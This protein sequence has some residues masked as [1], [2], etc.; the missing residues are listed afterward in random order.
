MKK[1]LAVSGGVDSMCL[2]WKY[3]NDSNVVVA[4]FDHGTRASSAED[5]LFVEK[6][7]KKLNLPFCIE[8][9]KLGPKVSEEEARSYRYAFLKK[10][11]K[12]LDGEIYTAHHLNDLAESIAINLSRG[13]SWRGLT[14]FSDQTI[15][16]PFIKSG[17]TKNDLLK[18]AAK[19]QITFRQDPTNTEDQYLRNRIRETITQLPQFD[20]LRLNDLFINQ[21]QKRLEIETII[22]SL[23]PEDHIFQ[24]AWFNN[25]DENVAVE[26]L[27]SAL[28]AKNI[29]A[30]R[31]QVLEFLFAINNY[32]PEKKFNL[33]GDHLVTMHKK[34]FML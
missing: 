7:T 18:Y 29:S 21:Q 11:A 17:L 22:A 28:L 23:L 4:H 10:L 13:T 5:A 1:I 3:R 14:P 32:S 26:L 30:T 6:Q 15:K 19:N 12:N 33:P 27:R 16:H 20:L 34:Y 25:L 9:A 2:L 31:P 24:R 8:R